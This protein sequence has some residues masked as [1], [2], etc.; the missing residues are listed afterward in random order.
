MGSLVGR[1]KFPHQAIKVPETFRAFSSTL[2]L[3]ILIGQF[4]PL[5]ANL[6]LRGHKTRHHEYSVLKKLSVRRPILNLSC[7]NI[8]KIG[9]GCQHTSDWRLLFIDHRSQTKD[10]SKPR[11]Q[12]FFHITPHFWQRWNLKMSS[13][14]V[15]VYS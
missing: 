13:M 3:S 12:P 8:S 1:R 15:S 14:L 4:I 6:N 2:K 7:R 11:T 9:R 10:E 5:R